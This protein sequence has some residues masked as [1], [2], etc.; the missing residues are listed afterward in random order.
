M[1]KKMMAQIYDADTAL[2]IN[3]QGE[4]KL[5][6]NL[7]DIDWFTETAGVFNGQRSVL[8]SNIRRAFYPEIQAM[9]QQLRGREDKLFS[10][11]KI[12]KRFEDHQAA[13]SEAV[14]NEDARAKYLEPSEKDNDHAYLPMLLGSKKAQRR[15]W[16]FNRM[17]Y[18]DS[19]YHTGEAVTKVITLRPNAVSEVTLIPY[20]DIY[21]EVI[22]GSIPVQKRATRNQSYTFENPLTTMGNTTLYIY[23]AGQLLDIGDLSGFQIEWGDFSAGENLY[24]IVLGREDTS[25][26][27]NL[28][29]QLTIGNN[30]KL[31]YVDLRG[32]MALG[33]GSEKSVDLSG[34]PN[35]RT[36]YAERTSLS[37]IDLSRSG[38]QLEILH[39]PDT[40]TDLVILNQPKIQDFVCSDYSKITKLWLENVPTLDTK[41]IMNSVASNAQVRLVDFDWTAADMNE[42]DTLVSRFDGFTGLDKDGYGGADIPAYI[43]GRIQLPLVT[44]DKLEEWHNA[45]PLLVVNGDHTLTYLYMHKTEDQ[46]SEYDIINC[47]DGVP[48]STSLTRTKASSQQYTYSFAGWS[49]YPG[50]NNSVDSTAFDDVT[51]NRH[52]YPVFTGTIRKYTAKFIDSKNNSTLYTQTNVAYGTTPT[53]G[54]PATS[55]LKDADG[56]D[57]LG[58]NPPLGPI[59]GD[60][61]YASTYVSPVE[62]KEIED[63]WDDI[64]AAQNDGSYKTKYKIGNMKPLDFGS[65]GTYMMQIV[66]FDADE[67]ADGSGYAHISWI[68][69]YLWPQS[70]RMNPARTA[71]RVGTGAIGGFKN[72]ELYG[73]IMDT[74]VPACTTTKFLEN[75]KEVKKYSTIYNADEVQ[76]K[77]SVETYTW[78]I[79]SDREMFNRTTY[80]TQGPTYSQ[81]FKDANSRKK[82]LQSSGSFH[83]AWLRSANSVNIWQ[84][85]N[86]NGDA[87]SNNANYSDYFALGACT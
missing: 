70:H 52:L 65:F 60:T 21:A 77:N 37:G 73:Y 69:Y 44:G 26:V 23:S 62:V 40:L 84:Q 71:N 34:C 74:C 45:Y 54:G 17:R 57:F 63:S 43:S 35:L 38:G 76:E 67:L 72:S 32:N 80:E 51:Q 81:I 4:L 11:E 9:Y 59:T 61:T 79:A 10:Y 41:M 47:T 3:N 55:T 36:L 5:D 66:A 64:F 78:W 56:N 83:R 68:G 87:Y 82:A 50:S 85:V 15:W 46:N 22:Y 16:L 42:V 39:Y 75:I 1:K 29:T 25:Y 58:W 12:I 14:F 27:N 28:L 33:T 8:W 48:E 19:K 2:G 30:S 86:S 31:L 20:A 49:R 13:W 24:R 7:E 6:Y 18:L 53:Y